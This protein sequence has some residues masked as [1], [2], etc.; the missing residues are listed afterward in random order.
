[1]DHRG[2]VGEPVGFLRCIEV[3]ILKVELMNKG[4]LSNCGRDEALIQPWILSNGSLLE[5]NYV[6]YLE[7][8]QGVRR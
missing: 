8:S 2:Y 6:A 5:N 7:P 1:M 3:G 4:R